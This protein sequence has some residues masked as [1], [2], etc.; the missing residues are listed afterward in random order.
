MIGMLRPETERRRWLGIVMS[1]S[2]VRLSAWM[3]SSACIMRR[4]PSKMKGFVT[5]PTVRA[6]SS[7]AVCAITGA[8]PVPVPPPM[9]AVTKTMS[10]PS[11]RSRIV[12]TSST[13]DSRPTAG[14]APAPSPLVIDVPIWS[15]TVAKFAAS[16]CASVF[17]AMKSTPGMPD[18]I[19]VFTALPPPPP[20]PTTLMRAPPCPPP[21]IL[22]IITPPPLVAVL[23]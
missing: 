8:P 5:T 18:W 9:P 4:L 14:F 12:S 11:S 2:T 22:S 16:A 23:A 17:A 3:P 10:A 21:P 13:A 19:I 1:V 15:F 20:T 7:R 6:P